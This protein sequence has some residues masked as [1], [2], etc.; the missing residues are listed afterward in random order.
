MCLWESRQTGKT[1]FYDGL[2][3]PCNAHIFYGAPAPL[4]EISKVKFS[5]FVIWKCVLSI[6]S[7][8]TYPPTY[9][10]TYLPAHHLSTHLD[11]LLPFSQFRMILMR[12]WR[13]AQITTAL[14]LRAEWCLYIW[15]VITFWLTDSIMYNVTVRPV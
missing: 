3:S 1:P 4:L 11:F 10:H 12:R 5:I 14:F 15:S 7:K 2:M 6:N 8:P 13:A 9:L